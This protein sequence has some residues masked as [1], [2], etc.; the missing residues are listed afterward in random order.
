M[1]RSS[2]CLAFCAIAMLTSNA[3]ATEIGDKAPDFSAV[4]IDGKTVT[5]ESVSQGAD[6]VVVCFTCNGC[7][8]ASGYE[9]RFIEFTNKYKDKKVVF[10]AINCNNSTENL[11]AVKERVEKKG[12]NYIYAFDETADAAKKYGAKVTPE[13]FVVQGGK[14]AYHGAFDDKQNKPTKSYLV[15]A[16]DSLLAGEKPEMAETKA[17]GCGIHS[18]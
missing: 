13:L 8:V 16:V 11:D 17:F 18:K 15:S 14:I 2:L 6:L 5:L 10:V 9:D 1:L 12:I 3:I 7:P 4:G